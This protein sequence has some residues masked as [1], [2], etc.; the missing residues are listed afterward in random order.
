MD[1]DGLAWPY[2]STGITVG[3]TV[4]RIRAGVENPILFRLW[5]SNAETILLLMGA[6][7]RRERNVKGFGTPAVTIY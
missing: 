4:S 5:S 6:K 2:R 3:G 1:M 7:R